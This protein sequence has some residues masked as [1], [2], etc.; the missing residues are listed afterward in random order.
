M[1]V[2]NKYK[3][4]FIAIPHTGSTVIEEVLVNNY[5]FKP[6]RNK[7]SLPVYLPKKFRGY[8]I[9][10]GICDP[11]SD[12]STMYWKFKNDH[13]GLY[14]EALKNNRKMIRHKSISNRGL[15]FFKKVNSGTWD[16][17]Q[18]IK[19][20]TSPFFVSRINVN[21]SM[22]DYIYHKDSLEKDWHKIK[23]IFGID[24]SFELPRKNITQNKQKIILNKKSKII[25]EPQTLS[26][27]KEKIK[28][29]TKKFIFFIFVRFK[30]LIWKLM[31]F[32][33]IL[34]DK[35]YRELR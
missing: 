13:L 24:D 19:K 2:S 6:I 5:G 23:F 9:V 8:K 30:V 33:K 21:K 25:L 22:Y 17:N 31:E 15:Y 3:S 11:L 28:P 35:N 10:G 1:L 12:M 34:I 20:S 14:S 32:K 16:F 4:I 27:K 18:F 29:L 7:H 26:F